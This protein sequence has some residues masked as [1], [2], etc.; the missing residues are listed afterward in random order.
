MHNE[1]TIKILSKDKLSSINFSFG[2]AEVG[3]AVLHAPEPQ[4]FI[5]TV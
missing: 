2:Q 3:S 5:V 1:Q 4:W